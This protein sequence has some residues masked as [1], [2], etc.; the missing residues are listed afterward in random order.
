MSIKIRVV[1]LAGFLLMVNQCVFAGTIA[2]WPFEGSADQ[3]ADELTNSVAP[4]TLTGVADIYSG[5]TL[6]AFAD[7]VPG[8]N[9]WNGVGG[10]L[11][12][13]DN[14]TSLL[15]TGNGTSGGLVRVTDDPVTLHPSNVTVEAFVK[16][17][18]VVQYSAIVRKLRSG[19]GASWGLYLTS[20]GELGLR[21]DTAAGANAISTETAN[22][23]L[24]D[25]NWH[26]VALVYNSVSSNVL[27]YVDYKQKVN[28]TLATPPLDYDSS[29]L[30]IG[31]NTSSGTFD[32][33]I[34]EVRI[35]DAALNED[36]FLMVEPIDPSGTLG[37]WD[38]DSD[39][40]GVA[41]STITSRVN[42]AYMTGVASRSGTGSIQPA[43][44]SDRADDGMYRIKDG[45]S[46]AFIHQNRSALQLDGIAK[47][48]GAKVTVP[49]PLLIPPPTNLTV[50]AFVKADNPANWGGIFRKERDGGPTWALSVTTNSTGIFLLG[51]LDT[52]ISGSDT[53]FNQTLPATGGNLA[54]GKWHHV[55]LTYAH[56]TRRATIYVDYESVGTRTTSGPLVYNSYDF[57]VGTSGSYYFDGGI[58]EIRLTGRVLSPDAFLHAAPPLGTCILLN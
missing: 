41:A 5:G 22:T 58:D 35:S 4:G 52:N 3:P 25:G 51:R 29:D 44:I 8:S 19:S 7:D 57:V 34:D 50:E 24:S 18:T 23:G 13:A 15:F 45:S 43:Y 53:G 27:M 48:V 2:W 9:V 40:T 38:L 47:N 1:S 12:N 42:A 11:Y 10:P 20:G 14:R 37:Y 16:V 54:D 36:Q 33:W 17:R 55:A 31:H 6:P 56:A 28:R 21:I 49:W 26:H 32:G 39:I 46:G 30:L